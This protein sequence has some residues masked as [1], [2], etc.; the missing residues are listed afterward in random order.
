MTASFTRAKDKEKSKPDALPPRPTEAWGT[1]RGFR[2]G[3]KP[4]PGPRRLCTREQCGHRAQPSPSPPRS[5]RHSQHCVPEPAPAGP[6]RYLLPVIR[7]QLRSGLD[8]PPRPPKLRHVPLSHTRRPPPSTSPRE[9]S[10]EALGRGMRSARFLTSGWRRGT[11]PASVSYSSG[12]SAILVL[13]PSSRCM[14]GESVSPSRGSGEAEGEPEG[15][16]EPG[17]RRRH[18]RLFLP[19]PPGRPLCPLPLGGRGSLRACAR[20]REP[21]R[22][23]TRA[24]SA[25]LRRAGGGRLWAWAPLLGG[26]PPAPGRCA[27]LVA[28]GRHPESDRVLNVG[29]PAAARERARALEPHSPRWSGAPGSLGGPSPRSRPGTPRTPSQTPGAG[30]SPASKVWGSRLNPDVHRCEDKRRTL[31]LHSQ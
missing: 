21:G 5:S 9:K 6:P 24:R 19:L 7:S 26:G 20:A 8:S 27:P 12:P 2:C 11:Q 31:F 4:A 22:P 28:A 25:A 15:E 14:P 10:P 1:T 13:N 18:R 3:S 30:P 29:K 23:R 16:R 17:R